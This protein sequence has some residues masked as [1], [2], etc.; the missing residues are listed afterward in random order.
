MAHPIALSEADKTA[1]RSAQMELLSEFDRV[2][3]THDL[4]YFA[5]YGTL[6]GAV[7]HEGFI[8]W[9][10]DL[11]VG[12]LRP[13]YE[14]LLTV[15]NDELGEGYFFQTVDSDE[16]YGC[17]FGKLRKD[18]TR[19]V[20]RISEGSPQHSGVF[21]DVFPLDARA[22]GRWSRREQ[23]AMR[24]I[25]FRLLYL[26]AGYLV[27]TGTSL[28]ARVLRGLARLLIGLVPRR[29]LIALGRR[30]TRLGGDSPDQYV[31]LFGA[32][33]YDRDTIDAAWVHPI[34]RVPFE[35]TTIPALAD[36]HAYLTQVYGDYGT[37]P[38]PE[39]QVGHHDLV[40]LDLGTREA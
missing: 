37:P 15:V 10:D 18:G 6:L 2:C 33:V 21:I 32:Y 40:E 29:L 8:P 27:M 26:K 22:T 17:F 30:T 16:H 3:R 20:D 28:P 1:L 11:D 24:Y 12:M 19:C 36:S 7:R 5:L 13:D 31:S 4:E 39:M 23:R 34:H 35:D 38:P 14:R 9:D 25:W